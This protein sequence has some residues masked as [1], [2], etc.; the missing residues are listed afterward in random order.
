[1]ALL[2]F[3]A[4]VRCEE[5]GLDE[6]R[7]AV[8]RSINV[9]TMAQWLKGLYNEQEFRAL[10]PGSIVL[11]PRQCGCYDQPAPHYPYLVVVL[12]TPKGDLILRPDQRELQ[13]SFVQLALRRGDLYCGMEPNGD[14]HGRFADVCDFTDLRYGRDLAPYFPTCKTG[15]D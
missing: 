4:A 2:T 9:E 10:E 11:E 1:M 7:P 8:P 12:S 14:C 3:A 15:E 6:P 13:V 5:P